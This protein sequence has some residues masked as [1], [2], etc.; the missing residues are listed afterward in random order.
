MSSK[1]AAAVSASLA[2]R[3]Q[4]S[5]PL[6]M[7]TTDG[8]H[9]W[10]TTDVHDRWGPRLV[11][12]RHKRT[13]R[14]LLLFRRKRRRGVQKPSQPAAVA[15]IV[16]AVGPTGNEGSRSGRKPNRGVS[17]PLGSSE[18]SAIVS[19]AFLMSDFGAATTIENRKEDIES[20]LH[21]RTRLQA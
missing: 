6:P 20:L 13:R 1:S 19:A 4:V 10:S 8:A 2:S 17:L 15:V 16:I 18:T 11:K 9:G 12:V 21:F 7:S 14:W 5:G 3:P